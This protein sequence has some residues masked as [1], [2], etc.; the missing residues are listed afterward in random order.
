MVSTSHGKWPVSTRWV[1]HPGQSWEANGSD[2][3]ALPIWR[4][5]R[6]LRGNDSTTSSIVWLSLFYFPCFPAGCLK[7]IRF[8]LFD[9]D[10]IRKNPRSKE[11]NHRF[12]KKYRF[13]KSLYL[14]RTHLK[15]TLENIEKKRR[16]RTWLE[17]ILGTTGDDSGR[18]L[19]L[20]YE[21]DRGQGFFEHLN[22]IWFSCYHQSLN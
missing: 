20:R 11:E 12:E 15:M 9:F 4:S 6:S 7:T 17:I 3:A 10:E 13:Q 2:E 16:E 5:Q 8:Y 14:P 18:T 1:V 19:M 22:E 21:K